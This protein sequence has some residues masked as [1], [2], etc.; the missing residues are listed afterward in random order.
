MSLRAIDLMTTDIKIVEPEMGLI[1]LERFFTNE[2]VS[3][4]P[5]ASGGRLIGVVS[6]SDVVRLLARED[7]QVRLALSFYYYLSPWNKEAAV[8]DLISHES[9]TML[10]RHL[11]TLTVRDAMTSSILAVPPDASIE[12]MCKEMTAHGVHR[13]LVVEGKTLRGLVSSLDVVRAVAERGL[14]Q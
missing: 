1:D 10:T 5:V 11:E 7:E 8:P 4:A 13:V 2:R 14:A 6:R 12:E 3:G 9:S